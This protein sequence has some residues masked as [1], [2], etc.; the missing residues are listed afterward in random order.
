[1]VEVGEDGSVGLFPLH[2]MGVNPEVT[3]VSQVWQFGRG[4][5][6]GAGNKNKNKHNL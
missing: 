5:G 1:M 4:I 2:L 3:V 6:W